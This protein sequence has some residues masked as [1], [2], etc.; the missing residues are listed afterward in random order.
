MSEGAAYT[1]RRARL[2]RW[3][4]AVA[5]SGP[6]RR[7]IPWFVRHYG[8]DLTAAQVPPGGFASLQ[9]FFCRGLRPGA[10]PVDQR[11]GV[12]ISPV[13]ATLG[14]RGRIEEG[15]LLQAK[16]RRYRLEHL[17][18]GHRSALEFQGGLYCTL[19]LAPRDYHRVH[20]PA[21]GTVVETYRVPGSFYPVNPRAVAKVGGLF[22]SNERVVNLLQCEHGALAVILVGACLVGGIRMNRQPV[23]GV[24]RGEEIGRFEFGST[25]IV[26]A[27]Q[28]A[29]L[30]LDHAGPTVR[31]G[32]KLFCAGVPARPAPAGN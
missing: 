31:M 18:D 25:V 20:A 26:L 22:A 4:G 17:L 21:A 11:A 6:S 24:E 29:G 3:A 19:Y 1:P 27:P 9:E 13:D 32:E 23:Y 7:L 12:V 28:A 16:G 15:V 2:S 10:R 5:R 30:R 8:V 14:A